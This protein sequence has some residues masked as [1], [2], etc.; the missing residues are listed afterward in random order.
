MGD[1]GG[2]CICR[3]GSFGKARA[4]GEPSE[5]VVLFGVFAFVGG[6]RGVISLANPRPGPRFSGICPVAPA[7]AGGAL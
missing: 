3:E 2:V 7:T 1:G 5:D 6:G 4:G